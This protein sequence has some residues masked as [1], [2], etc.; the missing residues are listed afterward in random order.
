MFILPAFLFL[1]SC[2]REKNKLEF[3]PVSS[4]EKTDSNRIFNSREFYA[5][6]QKYFLVRG[7]VA[8]K[9]ANDQVDSFV[10]SIKGLDPD[11]FYNFAIN[12]YRES[13][14]TNKKILDSDNRQIQSTYSYVND[15]L[16]CYTWIKGE[17][18]TRYKFK[19]GHIIDPPN[20]P[21]IIIEDVPK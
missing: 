3:I 4:L 13:D 21:R 10:Q 17:F 2:S 20:D 12:I 6:K 14:K 15:Y 19:N 5:S 11:S 16:F 18:S 9:I 1:N 8:T 7:Y